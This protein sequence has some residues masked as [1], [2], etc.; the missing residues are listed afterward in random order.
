MQTGAAEPIIKMKNVSKF[1]GPFQALNDVSLSIGEGERLVVCG[2]SGSGK[3][4]LIRC[5]NRL[6]KHETG[7]IEV[8]GI[9]LDDSQAALDA[10]RKN[11]GMVFQQFNLFPHLS[12][13]DNLTLG[14]MRAYGL[15]KAD[16]RVRAMRYL[17]RVRIPDQAEK[18]PRQLSGGQQ[19]R[20]AIARSLCMEPRILL[21]D[22]P[23]S[24]LDPEMITEVLDVMVELADTGM[25]MIV[26]TH[27]MGF[28]RK[29]AD[30]MVFMDAGEIVEEA[31]PEQFFTAPK[32]ARTRDFLQKIINH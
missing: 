14:P 3:S 11:V 9:R 20:V 6:E 24:A 31:K 18:L 2:P 17:E 32:S 7:E 13:I 15:S 26:V 29:V 21:F 1:F 23:T 27:E 19:Q 28:A 8:E 16:A 22:E 30:R 25:T 4:T 12:V 10:I 5:I